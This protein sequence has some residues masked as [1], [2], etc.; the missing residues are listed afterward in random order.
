MLT[1][2]EPVRFVS[3]IIITII[4]IIFK[5]IIMII[6]C[7]MKEKMP[8]FTI[9]NVIMMIIV[10]KI[11]IDISIEI[12]IN[13][14][15]STMEE[16]MRGFRELFDKFISE[17]GPSVEWENIQVLNGQ[18]RSLLYSSVSLTTKIMI[19]IRSCPHT[20]SSLTRA[21]LKRAQQRRQR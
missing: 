14:T 2:G 10:I 18:K 19:S 15:R 9:I 17:P 5:I 20:Q 3:K 6:F 11:I 16:E 7:Y 13:T 8:G 12:I 4:M 1:I 21:S